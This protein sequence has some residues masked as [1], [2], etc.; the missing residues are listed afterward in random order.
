MWGRNG[1]DCRAPS[2]PLIVEEKGYAHLSVHQFS[3]QLC[4]TCYLTHSL[5]IV[6]FCKSYKS[7]QS[8]KI[9]SVSCSC[10]H[11][12]LCPLTIGNLFIYL[13]LH[14]LL[15]LVFPFPK[16]SSDRLSSVVSTYSHS[17][18]HHASHCELMLSVILSVEVL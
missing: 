9:V 15:Y 5:I 7:P 13:K 14:S 6:F 4:L 1:R 3:L 10:F 12:L 11:V 2:S 16:H 17:R 8:F 18:W